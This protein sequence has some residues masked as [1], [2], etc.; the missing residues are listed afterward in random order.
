M[1]SIRPDLDPMYP[2]GE[3]LAVAHP[4]NGTISFGRKTEGFGV[5]F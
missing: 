1:P 2:C 3:N 4:G 5:R